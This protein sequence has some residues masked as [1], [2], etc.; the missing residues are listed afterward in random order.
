MNFIS[1]LFGEHLIFTDCAVWHLL[2]NASKPTV[3]LHLSLWTGIT[4]VP[5]LMF[6]SKFVGYKSIR[7]QKETLMR[8]KMLTKMLLLLLAFV[9]LF[10]I[11]RKWGHLSVFR[12]PP[13]FSLSYFIVS[14][15]TVGSLHQCPL[16]QSQP[17]PVGHAEWLSILFFFHSS[18]TIWPLQLGFLSLGQW[19]SHGESEEVCLVLSL[20]V[21][22]MS[23]HKGKS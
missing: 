21:G 1:N 6:V 19:S 11:G 20:R 3:C 12:L 7:S 18:F 9:I 2:T 23:K 14:I 8:Q 22:K 13:R 15:F 5:C 4:S 16:L 17:L 10:V